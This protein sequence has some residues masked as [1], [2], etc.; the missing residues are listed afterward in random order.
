MTVL[1]KSNVLDGL[2]VLIVED[3]YFVATDLA[4]ALE[5]AGARV[6]E[7]ISNIHDAERATEGDARYVDVVILDVNLRGEMV[8]DLAD[9]LLQSQVPFVFVTGYQ[10]DSL[11]ERYRGIP[12]LGKPCD[13]TEIVRV[14]RT[15]C[16][17]TAHAGLEG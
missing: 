14:I 13:D 10:C 2:S 7:P 8:F 17:R 6:A 1:A 16:D 4:M 5:D 3:E 15:V 9:R 12:C 11:P